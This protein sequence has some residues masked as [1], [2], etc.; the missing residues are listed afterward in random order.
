MIVGGAVRKEATMLA[1]AGVFRIAALRHDEVLAEVARARSGCGRDDPGGRPP[2]WLAAISPR[3]L[4]AGT[5]V[6]DTTPARAARRE[7]R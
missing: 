4:R 7:Q 5:S 3:P 1:N 6:I 2:P